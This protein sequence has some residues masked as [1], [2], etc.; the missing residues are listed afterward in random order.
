MYSVFEKL[1]QERKISTY[2]VAKETQIAQSVF[3]AWKNGISIPKTDKLQ[4]IADYFG[5]SIEYLVTGE[6][7]LEGIED[8]LDYKL[9]VIMASND[10]NKK[11]F[12][13]V[14][15]QLD[16]EDMQKIKELALLYI[17]AKKKG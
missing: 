11:D 13:E 2:K 17:E 7:L 5:V 4:K 8:E 9:G 10:A 6:E 1:L 12:L 3:S 16:D 15:L 14:V